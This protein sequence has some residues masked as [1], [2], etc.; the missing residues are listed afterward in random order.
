MSHDHEHETM[1]GPDGT[2]IFKG[3]DGLSEM[4][5]PMPRWMATVFIVTI[6]WGVGYIVLMPGVG[7]NFLGWGQ[8]KQYEAEVAEAKAKFPQANGDAA[9]LVAAA[10]ADHAAIERG[11]AT[12]KQNC[13][14]CHGDKGQG[15]IGPSFKDAV[16]L[17]GGKP[18]EIVHTITDGTTKGMPPFKTALGATQLA[19]VA[20]Y[21]HALN[22]GKED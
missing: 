2:P 5:N 11:E 10:V 17:Y 12:F 9:T 13:A 6:L 22:T 21:V 3:P 4:D 18:T 8:Y 20:A 14:A 7:L 16:W 1:I 19:E 15:A